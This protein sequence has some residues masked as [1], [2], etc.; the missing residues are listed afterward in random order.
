MPHADFVHLR[1]HSAYS[2]SAGA[3]KTKELVGLCKRLGMP[4][5]AVTDAGNLFGALEFSL[6]AS[7]AGIQPIIGCELGL[8][9]GEGEGN[10][11]S[12]RLGA[13]PPPDP[14]VLLVQNETGYR[15]LLKLV[16]KSF[17]ETEGGEPPQVDIAALDGASEGLL[18]LTGGPT[19]PVGR[20][21]LEGQAESAAAKLTRLAGLFPGRTYVELQ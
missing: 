8:R 20:L 21:L 1:V 12:A 3:I 13:P 6:A 7:D 2:L 18:L 16:S 5:V 11:R 4:A 15:N 14:V 9:R 17:L 19:G 10:G